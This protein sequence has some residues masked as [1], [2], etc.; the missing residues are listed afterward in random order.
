[1]EHTRDPLI[2]SNFG[3]YLLPF[4]SMPP[5]DTMDIAGKEN[6]IRNHT[7]N[8]DAIDGMNVRFVP[9][10]PSNSFWLKTYGTYDCGAELMTSAWEN[11]EHVFSIRRNSKRLPPRTTGAKIITNFPPER[12]VPLFKD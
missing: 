5:P 6:H 7:E 9:S 11:L 2:D 1:M 12:E 4:V 3:K 10:Q 8:M